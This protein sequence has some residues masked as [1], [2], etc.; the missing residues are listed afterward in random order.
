MGNESQLLLV[1]SKSVIREQV[2]TSQMALPR[3]DG[4]FKSNLFK[5]HQNV[6]DR[7]G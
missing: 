6:I 4:E 3:H 1:T 7:L 5:P 2:N